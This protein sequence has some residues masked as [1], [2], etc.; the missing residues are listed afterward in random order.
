[1]KREGN[2]FPQLVSFGN[3]LQAAK[4]AQRGKRFTRQTLI[5]N[6]NL[7]NEL[8]RLREELTTETYR[9]GAY[10]TFEIYEPKRRM[11]S[12]APYR[13]RVVHHAPCNVIGPIFERT[14]IDTSYANRVGFGTSRA[15]DR[16]RR[17]IRNSR[18]VLQ[19]DI[20]R[21]FPSIDHA[22]LKSFIRRKIKCHDTLRLIDLIIDNSNPQEEVTAYFPGDDLFTPHERRRG[23]PIGNLTSQF[24]ANIYLNGFDH[25]V[26]EQLGI[27]KY[28]RYV[29]DFALFGDD[30]D[31]LATARAA[32]EARL[33]ELRLRIHPVK[34]QL[35]ETRHGGNFVGFRVFKE[36]VRVRR[37]TMDRAR[38][39]HRRLTDDY[40]RERI[41]FEDVARSLTSWNAH[42]SRA[43]AWRLRERV[44]ASL[45]FRRS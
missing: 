33:A 16:F 23:L 2:L 38:K 20:Y 24:F 37:N 40:A 36:F 7:E 11:I 28:L 44:L 39:R 9:P 3:L 30:P 10:F 18:Y 15:F 26:K 35:F 27:R 14:F 41:G 32:I 1:M 21:Y 22:I 29:D 43:D 8:L 34:S 5:F 31:E 25:F 19:C 17:Y 6:H 4:Q 45:V 12:A 42:V 13:D